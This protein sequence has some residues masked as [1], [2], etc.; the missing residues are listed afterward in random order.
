MMNPQKNWE[1]RKIRRKNLE[2]NTV[3]KFRKDDKNGEKT[4]KKIK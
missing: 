4:G 1:N 3:K 2:T